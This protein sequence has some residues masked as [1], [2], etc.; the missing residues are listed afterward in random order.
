MDSTT[1]Y[2]RNLRLPTPFLVVTVLVLSWVVTGWMVYPTN[3]KANCFPPGL[4]L[5][6][7]IVA[8]VAVSVVAMIVGFSAGL[9]YRSLAL[10]LS[11]AL[12]VS[13]IGFGFFGV[14][15][16]GDTS[17][18]EVIESRNECGRLAAEAEAWGWLIA[19]PA[20][21]IALATAAGAFKLPWGAVEVSATAV[22]VCLILI[23]ALGPG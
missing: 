13:A 16:V 14:F 9:R 1:K 12:L 6:Q 15:Y 5:P 4:Q 18:P 2:L 8:V 19:L 17:F 7:T 22:S 23:N 10:V 20:A 3:A 21:G 11:S